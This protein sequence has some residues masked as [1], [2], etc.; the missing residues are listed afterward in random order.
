MLRVAHVEP[1][2]ISALVHQLAQAFPVSRSPVQA[3]K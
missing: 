2:D 1:E 3:C